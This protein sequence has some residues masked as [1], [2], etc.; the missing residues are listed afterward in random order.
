MASWRLAKSL[1]SLE[2]EIKARYPGTTVWTIGDQEHQSGASDHNPNSVGVVCA[3]DVLGNAGLSLASLAEALRTSGHPQLK[4]VIFNRRIA[5]RKNGWKWVTYHG[6]NPHTT[7]VHASVGIGSDGNSAP[8]TYDS[9]VTWGVVG[10]GDYDM[11]DDMIGLKRG[12]KGANV[13]ALQYVLSDAG[14]NP[15]EKDGQY[16][17]NT[18]KQVLAMRKSTGSAATDGDELTAAAYAQ[19]LRCLIRNQTKNLAVPGPRG[20]EGPAGKDGKDGADGKLELPVTV[21]ITDVN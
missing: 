1:Q 4:Y 16:G 2:T 6:S 20:P 17:A 9:T 18:A 7:H 11:G 3:I 5:T 8:G 13:Q 12:D 21:V 19:L 14:F 15:G 10:N